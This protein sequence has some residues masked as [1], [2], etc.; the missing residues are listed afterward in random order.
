MLDVRRAPKSILS[1]RE[2]QDTVMGAARRA[3]ARKVWS[4]VLYANDDRHKLI[5]SHYPRE[6]LA[7][8]HSKQDADLIAESLSRRL[9]HRQRAY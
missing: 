1:K 5:R 6:R 3:V 7:A 8:I 9:A 4:R 2:L